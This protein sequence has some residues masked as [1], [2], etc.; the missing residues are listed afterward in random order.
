[1]NLLSR[2][3]TLGTLVCLFGAALIRSTNPALTD[4]PQALPQGCF[5]SFE[6][7]T[8]DCFFTP[9]GEEP[10]G[11]TYTRNFAFTGSGRKG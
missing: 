1:M 5:A 7:M 8:E 6:S 9:E 3:L 11:G 10:C 2:M 4:P